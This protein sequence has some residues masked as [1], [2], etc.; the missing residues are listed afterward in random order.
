MKVTFSQI[1]NSDDCLSSKSV[2]VAEYLFVRNSEAIMKY[3]LYESRESVAH[4][5]F[6]SRLFVSLDEKF[7]TIINNIVQDQNVIKVHLAKQLIG[8]SGFGTIE[9]LDYDPD[10]VFPFS[11]KPEWDRIE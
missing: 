8:I 2:E 1:N 7:E 6:M 3:R 5:S 10:D 9:F 11:P 4:S